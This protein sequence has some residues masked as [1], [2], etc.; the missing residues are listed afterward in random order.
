[1]LQ[2]EELGHPLVELV[3]ADTGDVETHHVEGLH[4]GFVVE[5]P[6]QE[7][8]PAHQV[9]GRNRQR[10]LL[11]LPQQCEMGGQVLGPARR[12]ERAVRQLHRAIG[13]RFAVLVEG[14][15]GLQMAVIVVERE[16]LKLHQL[17]RRINRTPTAIVAPIL[18]RTRRRR[19][20][21]GN[22]DHS[23]RHHPAEDMR[24]PGRLRRSHR[25]PLHRARAP[26]ASRVQR[27][28]RR[29]TACD[30]SQTGHCNRS[31]PRR[32]TTPQR[33]TFATC[34]SPSRSSQ[35]EWHPQREV[36]ECVDRRQRGVRVSVV[37]LRQVRSLSA[38]RSS[39]G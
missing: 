8:A 6:G 4:A 20:R 24:A 31:G 37:R 1:M 12:N 14:C 33:P 25:T 30:T 32:S 5:E 29:P 17:A 26:N 38:C 34:P 3:V 15:I 10:V 28:E 21:A 7:R 22:G 13:E 18:P 9:A 27:P 16:Q 35:L 2:P 39:S 11:S 36:P 19:R 23:N